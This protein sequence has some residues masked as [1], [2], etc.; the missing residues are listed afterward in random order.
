MNCPEL[1]HIAALTVLSSCCIALH[2]KSSGLVVGTK[3]GTLARTVL[4]LNR[5]S[6]SLLRSQ[7]KP[8]DGTTER[9]TLRR[10]SSP[11]N[12]SPDDPTV[13]LLLHQLAQ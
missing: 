7:M 1:R 6:E 8:R 5:I 11:A 12:K 2:R 10:I 13:L 3:L 4:T 9:T